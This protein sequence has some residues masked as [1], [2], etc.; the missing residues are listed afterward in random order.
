MAFKE[1]SQEEI[2]RFLQ[3]ERIIRIGMDANGERYLVPLGYVWHDGAIYCVTIR[4]KKTEMATANPQVSFQVDNSVVTGP[5]GWTS[6]IGAGEVEFV[7]RPAEI[8][9]VSPIFWGR[10]TDMP[11]WAAKEYEERTR[12]G[13]LVWLR[14][15]P[16]RM[17]GRENGPAQH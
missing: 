9:E 3:S 2:A 6:V 14:I 12:L 13:A 10:F 1:L 5:F 8:D 16:E 7:T 11:E 4:G 15:R 17:T